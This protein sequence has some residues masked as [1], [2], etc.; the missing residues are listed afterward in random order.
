MQ[1]DRN[2]K[3]CSELSGK[4]IQVRRCQQPKGPP[5]HDSL[6]VLELV[7]KLSGALF[8]EEGCAGRTKWWRVGYAGA[9]EVIFTNGG[10]KRV[11][12]TAAFGGEQWRRFGKAVRA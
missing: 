9:A 8:K 6:A 2:N 5:E 4:F 12:A 7:D 1:R 10:F 11:T 3:I